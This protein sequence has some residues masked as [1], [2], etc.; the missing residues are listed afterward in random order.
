MKLTFPADGPLVRGV[1]PP[2]SLIPYSAEQDALPLLDAIVGAARAV[3]AP[4]F[5]PGHKMGIGAPSALRR[6]LLG[7]KVLRHDLPEL[8]ELDNLFAPEGPILEAERLAALAFGAARTWLLVNGSTGGVLAAILACVQLWSQRQLS[9]DA[10]DRNASDLAP[11]VLLPRNAHKS[12]IHALVLSG[13]QPAW[14]APAYD[15][16]SGISLGIPPTEIEQALAR[17]GDRIA[18]VLLVSPTYQGV[19]CDIDAAAQLTRDAAVPLVVDEAHGGH[20]EF[21]PP[22][23]PLPASC[24]ATAR[25]R[26][27]LSQGADFAVQS[28][29]KVCS[30]PFRASWHVLLHVTRVTHVAHA[31]HALHRFSDRSHRVQCSTRPRR[32]SRRGPP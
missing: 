30:P 20:L 18:A 16:E 10:S 21:L 7:G 4:F 31:L 14:L 22:S 24:P 29:H 27:A 25:P 23:A 28:T 6:R 15:A 9:R 11:V 2:R 5:F 1:P 3:R 17:H 32:R 19:L 12:A 8:P 13:A 26:S